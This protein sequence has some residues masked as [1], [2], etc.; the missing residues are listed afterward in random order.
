MESEN[1]TNLFNCCAGCCG[2]LCILSLVAAIISYYVFGIL[3]LVQDYEI[4]KECEDSLLWTYVLVTLILAVCNGGSAKKKEENPFCF[5][6]GTLILQLCLGIWGGV[7]LWIKS[8]DTLIDS[9]IWIF[10]N[11]SFGLQMTIIAFCICG[12][13]ISCYK[14]QAEEELNAI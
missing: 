2:C 13:F 9:N 1:K 14:I 4:C 6:L 8:C 11:W 10:A 5:Y 7:E 12:I 3:Y